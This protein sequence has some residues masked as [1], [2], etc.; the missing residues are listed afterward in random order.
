MEKI[1]VITILGRTINNEV[2]DLSKKD[3]VL[4]NV[5]LRNTGNVIRYRQLETIAN[6][7]VLDTQGGTT[8]S[9]E[10]KLR[11]IRKHAIPKINDLFETEY[12]LYT[13]RK[14]GIL[15]VDRFIGRRISF[16]N[17]EIALNQIDFS[18][19][20]PVVQD[21]FQLFKVNY[22]VILSR[23]I[24]IS[25]SQSYYHNKNRDEDN[26][27]R[28]LEMRLLRMNN[29]LKKYGFRVFAMNK[30]GYLLADSDILDG[31]VKVRKA[32]DSY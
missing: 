6:I 19:E 32:I 17:K 18:Q 11:R 31:K 5:L 30:R 7:R 25:H 29:L 27:E 28:A 4:L 10:N 13:L 20:S 22:G 3:S 1:S 23:E 9:F 14:S 12:E 8:R 15:L 21:L 24:V 16:H 2:V 26:I